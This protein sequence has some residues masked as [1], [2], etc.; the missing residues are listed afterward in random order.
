M[1]KQVLRG[2]KFPS[3]PPDH[4]GAVYFTHCV[5]YNRVTL[6]MILAVQ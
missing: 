4:L 5:I 2:A 1:K 6:Y 3:I